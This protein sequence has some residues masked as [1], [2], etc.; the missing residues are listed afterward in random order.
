MGKGLLKDGKR[1]SSEFQVDI[2]GFIDI[3]CRNSNLCVTI[4]V[5]PHTATRSTDVCCPLP[6]LFISLYY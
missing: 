1:N 3:F 4:T 2:V 5:T 6:P